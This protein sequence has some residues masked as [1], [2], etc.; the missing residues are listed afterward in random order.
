MGR[1]LGDL[2]RFA[3]LGESETLFGNRLESVGWIGRSLR[4][5][6]VGERGRPGI[7]KSRQGRVEYS[8]GLYYE[9]FRSVE[10]TGLV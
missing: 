3:E 1:P 7:P 6:T 4:T 5:S 10:E 2:H 8:S 9:G